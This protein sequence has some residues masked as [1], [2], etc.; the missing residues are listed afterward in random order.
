MTK[1]PRYASRCGWNALLPKRDPRMD[2]PTGRHHDCIVV[3]AGFTGLAAARRF[4]E[5][6]PDASVLLLEAS[7]VGEGSSARNAG[8]AVSVPFN[9]KVGTQA[10]GPADI[11]QLDLYESGLSQLES[12]V[13]RHRIDC[14]WNPAMKIHAAATEDG[15]RRMRTTQETY[16]QWGILTQ[17]LDRDALRAHIGTDYYRYGF[18]SGRNVFLQPAALV[19]GLAD[20]LP[21]N[22]H[23]LEKTLVE[24]LRQG[25][26]HRVST[27]AGE[28]TADKV[29]LANNAF[30]RE[31][32]FLRS[33]MVTIFTYAA[34]TPVLSQAQRVLLAGPMSRGEEWGIL[35][36]NRMGTTVRRVAG[37]R[38]LI[39]SAYSYESEMDMDSVAR[40]L[41]ESYRRRFPDLS[42]HAFEFVWGGTTALTNNGASYFGELAPGVFSFA[43]CNGSG[44]VKCSINGSL[45]AERACGITSGHLRSIE[46]R[47]GPSWIPPGPLR[48]IGARTSIA[49]QAW[50]A[51]AER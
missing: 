18:A 48:A 32:G 31:F 22:V 41:G 17:S 1:I 16:R 47:S 12:L 27:S 21:A 7:T 42:S 37:G 34:L 36:A 43:G 45:L 46:A 3:G 9:A 8:F 14:G 38:M 39:R 29:I 15:E 30:V 25:R 44:I 26:P 33:R 5:L 50:R 51:G 35:P 2:A 13:H 11:A 19:R 49:W 28:F 4:A 10:P 24:T 40:L 23:L 20:S 6:A